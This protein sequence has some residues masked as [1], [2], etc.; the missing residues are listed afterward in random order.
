MSGENAVVTDNKPTATA[1]IHACADTV[2]FPVYSFA[3]ICKYRD[4]TVTVVAL[5]GSK[6]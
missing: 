4:V 3:V 1:I 2:L 6:Y 5:L